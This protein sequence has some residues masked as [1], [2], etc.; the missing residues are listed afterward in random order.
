MERSAEERAVASVRPFRRGD[1]PEVLGIERESFSVP[2]S[3][4]AFRAVLG[5]SDAVVLVA[6]VEGSVAG[7]AVAWFRGAVGELG[8]LAVRGD[9]RR[10][11]IGAKLVRRVQEEAERR[12]ADG[13]F[14]QVRESNRPARALYA[15]AG[16]RVTGR[17][18]GYYRS[19]AEDAV[20]MRWEGDAGAGPREG[21]G[22]VDEMRGET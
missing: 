1:L 17:R 13:L 20:V 7:Y 22:F 16:F 14:L 11:G 5:R 9:L 10:R 3:E 15:D 6:D 8:D 2:W 19:P 18:E 4:G 21:P 12:G